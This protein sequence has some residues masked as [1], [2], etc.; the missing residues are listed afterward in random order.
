[1][2]EKIRGGLFNILGDIDGLTVLDC[3]A[4]TGAIAFEAISRGAKSAVVVESNK[5]AQSS[6]I[7]NIRNLELK[8]KVKLIDS[9]VNQFVNHHNRLFD[10]VICDPP[11]D[12]PVDRETILRLERLVSDHGL[13]ILSLPI[14]SFNMSFEALSVIKEK[15]YGDARLVFFRR[16]I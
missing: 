14:D 6:I 10:L 13:L 9:T 2:S 7:N 3:Y 5:K 8:A 16:K 4:G 15:V 1:M 11:F 12:Q